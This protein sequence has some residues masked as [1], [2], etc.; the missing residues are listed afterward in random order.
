MARRPRINSSGFHHIINRGVNK[1]KI[2]K[3]N[4]DKDKF[5]DILCKASKTY[6]VNIHDYCLMDNHYHILLETSSENLSLFA[7]AINSN[8]AIYFNKQYKRVGHL[9]QGRYKSYYIVDEP[10]LYELFRYIEHNPLKA[11]MYKKV[12]DYPYTLLHTLLNED[13][14]IISCAN[15]SKLKK[16][17]HYEGIQDL[18]E[19]PLNKK[20]LKSLKEKQNK[21][22]I[23]NE[24]EFK[25][26]KNKTLKEY[27]YNIKGIKIRN[28]I[29]SLA[30]EDGYTQ[31][32]IARYLKISSSMVSKIFRGG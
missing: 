30:L 26:L 4:K 10:Y 7:R 21:K 14:D 12:G 5:L 31:A 6:K 27:F 19:K 25:M 11:K 22:I 2:Y 3:S 20:E 32:D 16:E 1:S 15:H 28:N 13:K 18:L 24:Y 29:I 17:F 23:Q 8:Y 9:W